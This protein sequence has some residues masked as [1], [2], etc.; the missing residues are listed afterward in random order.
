MAVSQSMQTMEKLAI[1]GGP[2]QVVNPPDE[3]WVKVNDDAKRAVM[4]LLEEGVTSIG[5]NGGIIGEF[6]TAFAEMVGTRYA[7]TMTNGTAALHSAYFAI[8]VGPGDEVIVPTYT[9]HATITPILHCRRNTMFFR[10]RSR[11]R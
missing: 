7:L 1:N 2:S 9:W 8:G 3:R 10:H 4:A 11:L 6:E 5:G